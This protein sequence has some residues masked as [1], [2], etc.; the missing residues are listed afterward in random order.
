MEMDVYKELKGTTVVVADDNLDFAETLKEQ[1]ERIG[2]NVI[3]VGGERRAG[4]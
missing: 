1:L 4:N 3:G 2:L